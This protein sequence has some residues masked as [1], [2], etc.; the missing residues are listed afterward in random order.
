MTTIFY[1]ELSSHLKI[2]GEYLG[3][4]SKNPKVLADFNDN[5]ILEFFPQSNEYYPI[6]SSIKNPCSIKI[7]K[8]FDDI[9]I[10]PVYERKRNLPYK[11]IFQKSFNIYQG[12]L[13]ITVIQDG[14]YKFYLDGLLTYID[15][16]PFLIEECETKE[17]QNILFI[18]FKGKKQV[19]FAFDLKLGKLAYKSLADS[20]D[21]DGVFT[22]TNFYNTAIPVNVVER[23]EIPNFTLIGRSANTIKNQYEINPKLIGVSFFEFIA[24]NLDTTFLL[25]NNIKSREKELHGFIG[26]PIVI[27]PYYKDFKKTVVVLNDSVHLYNLEYEN[28]FINNILEE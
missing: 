26:K 21:F 8:L 3:T 20:V 22:V 6:T 25:S 17:V 16:L 7:F 27:F 4:I 11:L 23:W 13:L 15:E 28:G 12:S 18:I 1:S 9:I 19:I 2:N 14:Y 5:S 10:I 24:L